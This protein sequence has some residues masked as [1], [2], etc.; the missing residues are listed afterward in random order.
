MIEAKGK[1]LE[2]L[3]NV[4]E[5]RIQQ[6]LGIG[7]PFDNYFRFKKKQLVIILGHDNVG[8]TYF[9]TWYFLNLA[10]VN[11]VKFCIWSGE[12]QSGQIIRDMIQMLSGKQFKELSIEE[13]KSYSTIIEDKF[14]FIDNANLYKPRDLLRLFE[15]SDCNACLIDPYTG[16]DREMSWESNYNFLNECRHFCNRTGK[17]IYV[18]THPITDSGRQGNI[19]PEKHMWAGHLRAPMKDHI[20]GGKAFL[21]RCDDML[22]VHRLTKHE[23]MRYYTLV[24]IEKIKDVET[25]GRLTLLDE[26]ILFDYNRGKGFLCE[27]IDSLADYRKTL[28]INKPK[29]PTDL[30][31][32]LNG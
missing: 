11:N 29:I 24:T 8:K 7:I 9:T 4:K 25:G 20:E 27:G 3:I 21:N 26:P 23:A 22:V 32:K 5:G 31:S 19:Y 15:E 17:T 14:D 10:V 28:N 1:N 2:Y 16:L 13:I 18:N 12:N 30:W 6:G